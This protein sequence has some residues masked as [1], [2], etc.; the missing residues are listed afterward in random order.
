MRSK[1][2]SD[3]DDRPPDPERDAELVK[4]LKEFRKQA[5]LDPHD[6]TIDQNDDM[7]SIERK[8]SRKRG[9]WWQ[10]PKDLPAD[11]DED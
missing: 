1:K 3:K 5:T 10:V 11:A 6:P 8:I 9:S 7:L 4:R 2:R